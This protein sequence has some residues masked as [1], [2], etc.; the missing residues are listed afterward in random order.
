MD[1]KRDTNL[2]KP[3][4]VGL[5]AEALRPKFGKLWILAG[6]ESTPAFHPT[7]NVFRSKHV[8]L[9]CAD[10]PDLAYCSPIETTIPLSATL[11]I[12]NKTEV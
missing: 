7:S 5:N 8:L 12:T 11:K 10:I 1:F 2:R 3:C 4:I 9:E 6:R